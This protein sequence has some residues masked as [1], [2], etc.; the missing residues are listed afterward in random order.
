MLDPHFVEMFGKDWEGQQC[1][2]WWAFRFQKHMALMV[3]PL[4]LMFVVQDVNSLLL[5]QCHACL[6]DAML[7]TVMVTD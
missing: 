5:L 2:W 6:P 4:C 7:P 1:Q 3:S